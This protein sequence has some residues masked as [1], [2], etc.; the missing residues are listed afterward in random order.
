MLYQSNL[1]SRNL[2]GHDQVL[3]ILMIKNIKYPLMLQ[4]KG[5][6]ENDM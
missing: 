5:Q 3:N 2:P 1:V 6:N 4:K